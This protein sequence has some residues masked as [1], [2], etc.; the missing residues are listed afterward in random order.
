MRNLVVLG[1]FVLSFACSKN[2]DAE[3]PADLIPREKFVEILTEMSLLESHIQAT[4]THVSEFHGLMERSGN[5][6]LNQHQVSAKQYESSMDYYAADQQEMKSI[7]NEVLDVLN[8][9]S[10]GY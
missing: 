1:L 5:K 3:K 8:R 6:I 4:Y 7:Y 9:K 2:T 10:S